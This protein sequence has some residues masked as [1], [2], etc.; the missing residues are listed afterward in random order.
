V[1]QRLEARFGSRA[2]CRFGAMT[3]GGYKV[4]ITMP[5]ETNG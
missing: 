3:S 2:S 1:S 5:I 4:A